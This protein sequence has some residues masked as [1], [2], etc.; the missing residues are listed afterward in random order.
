MRVKQVDDYMEMLFGKP[1]FSKIFFH[2]ETQMWRT[3]LGDGAKPIWRIDKD[4]PYQN[5][6]NRGERRW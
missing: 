1:D 6:L 4:F 2:Y 3:P 5:P